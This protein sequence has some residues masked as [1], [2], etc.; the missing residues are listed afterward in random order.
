MEIFKSLDETINNIIYLFQSAYV[1]KMAQTPVLLTLAITKQASVS[2]S[3]TSSGRSATNAPKDSG[4]WAAVK[5]VKSVIVVERAQPRLPAVR[6]VNK[7]ETPHFFSLS[8]DA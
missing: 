2:V 4:T 7:K 6:Y 5:A 1:T 8:V 3:Q